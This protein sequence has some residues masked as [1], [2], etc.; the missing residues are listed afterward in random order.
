MGL[1][2]LESPPGRSSAGRP[3]VETQQFTVEVTSAGATATAQL[4]L[5]VSDPDEPLTIVTR[6]VPDA[7][8]GQ[9]YDVAVVVTGRRR[10]RTR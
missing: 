8:V 5:T 1:G 4:S 7:V 2:I 3:R 6:S 10:T 9:D